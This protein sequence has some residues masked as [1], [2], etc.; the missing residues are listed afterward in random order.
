VVQIHLHH[1]AVLKIAAA[2]VGTIS[3][4]LPDRN[5]TERV[6]ER[7]AVRALGWGLFRYEWF[8]G[9]WDNDTH[10]TSL[11]DANGQPFS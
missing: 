3:Q 4:P 10:F 8:T 7:H 6:T 5:R 2:S 9:R 11:L 1:V